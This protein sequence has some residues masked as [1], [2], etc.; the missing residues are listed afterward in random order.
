ME[1]H[2]VKW[3]ITFPRCPWA[4]GLFECMVRSVKGCLRTLLR[5]AMLNFDE[6]HAVLTEIEC[7]LNS[8]PLTYQ[9]EDAEVLTPCHLITGRHFSPVSESCSSDFDKAITADILTK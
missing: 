6:L 4:G 8:R 2:R 7:T 3:H 1:S 5:N 9:H